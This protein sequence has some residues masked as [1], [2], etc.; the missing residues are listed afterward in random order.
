MA[1]LLTETTATTETPQTVLGPRDA[2]LPMTFEEFD[3]AGGEK[4]Y[5]YELIHGVL[6]VT[7][8]PA[9]QERDEN[10]ELGYLLRVYHDQ[11]PDGKAFGMSLGVMAS[12]R[13]SV[14]QTSVAFAMSSAC[15]SSPSLASKNRSTDLFGVGLVGVRVRVKVRMGVR[16]RVTVRV[17]V[18]SE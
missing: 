1:D 12:G 4:G 6:I 18:R 7:P 17:K 14:R 2:G 5:R 15:F 10:Q 3:A 16:V 9:E 11:H 13:T 8:P